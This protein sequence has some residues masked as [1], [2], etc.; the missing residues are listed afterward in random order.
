MTHPDT[1]LDTSSVSLQPVKL[2]AK[3]D[4]LGLLKIR[5]LPSIFSIQ[6]KARVGPLAKHVWR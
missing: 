3:T 2:K 5:P 4:Y 1:Y 6:K